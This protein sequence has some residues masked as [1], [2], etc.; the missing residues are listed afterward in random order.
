[1]K[2]FSAEET[3][4]NFAKEPLHINHADLKRSDSSFYRSVCPECAEGILLVRRDLESFEL[5]AEDCCI[6]CA[7]RFIYADIEDVRALGKDT[8][9]ED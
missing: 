1:M 6:V 4:K 8:P 2:T 7:R 3:A 5:L 9:N